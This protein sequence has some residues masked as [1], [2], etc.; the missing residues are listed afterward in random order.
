MLKKF[1]H[2]FTIWA[3]FFSQVTFALDVKVQQE[4]TIRQ[5]GKDGLEVL[6]RLPKGTVLSIPDEFVSSN[7]KGEKRD[8][9]A[10]TNWLKSG[11]SL[12]SF[13]A[14]DGKIK[15]DYFFP[16][17]VVSSPDSSVNEGLQGEVALQ[18]LAKKSGIQIITVAETDLYPQDSA[19]VRMTESDCSEC[20]LKETST[21]VSDT[22]IFKELTSKLQGIFSKID[23]DVSKKV[24]AKNYPSTYIDNFNETCG[25]SFDKFLP[26]L[27]E[28]AI[29]KG[30][31]PEIMLGIMSAESEGRCDAINQDANGT[32]SVGLFQINTDSTKK[33]FAQLKDPIQNL[34]ESI[35]ILVDKYKKVNSGKSPKSKVAVK[36]MSENEKTLWRKALSAYNGG[37]GHLYQS[38]SDL[39]SFNKRYGLKLDTED[40]QER[41]VF[42]FRKYLEKNTSAKFD[43]QYKYRRST[44]NSIANIVYVESILDGKNGS[45]AII[46]GWY[47]ELI[48]ISTVSEN[49]SYDDERKR[50]E[51]ERQKRLEEEKRQEEE[52]QKRIE[53]EKRR[54]EEEKKRLE[55]EEKRRIEEQKRLQEEQ[56][57]LEEE[58]KK[59]EEERKRLE[60][61]RKK[62]EEEARIKAEEEKKRLEEERKR[63]EEERRLAEEARKKAEEENRRKAEEDKRL[64]DAEQALK[65][66]IL[67]EEES[68]KSKEK[69]YQRMRDEF[70][71]KQQT[72]FEEYQ[73]AL[74]EEAKN[75]AEQD[76]LDKIRLENEELI[77]LNSSGRD[78]MPATLQNVYRTTILGIARL[79]YHYRFR[80]ESSKYFQ[81]CTVFIKSFYN[82]VND[83]DEHTFIVPPGGSKE[84]TGTLSKPW[85][86]QGAR[87]EKDCELLPL[88][89]KEP[90]KAPLYGSPYNNR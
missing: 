34:R 29:S 7:F 1:L 65:D 64:Q 33:N 23:A 59:Q 16:V 84:V 8:Q 36:L 15:R 71:R 81:K 21:P 86:G 10:L 45:G 89:Y 49:K 73:R 4:L 13:V 52:R 18:Y 27:K 20:R 35:R 83:V 68:T 38:E 79:K 60:E 57:R 77:R 46:D 90:A 70:E 28:E 51:E 82:Q 25:M 88:D 17:K 87:V 40:W 54:A 24:E 74:E 55:E 37:E 2:L 41:K 78:F 9:I 5:K 63:L 58:R 66:F 30:I 31:P 75:K 76:R 61:E 11:G 12:K 67:S 3:L 19:G 39:L 22:N 50:L 72:A 14:A 53:E 26:I 85:V 47:P 62:R 6:A 69:E 44:D 32:Y 80:N 42:Y 48:K 56:K 43:N